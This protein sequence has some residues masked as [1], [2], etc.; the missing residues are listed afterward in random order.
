MATA[1]ASAIES[2][3]DSGF[4]GCYATLSRR[5]PAL[6]APARTTGNALGRMTTTD[7]ERTTPNGTAPGRA[8]PA[9]P[10]ARTAKPALAWRYPMRTPAAVRI[11]SPPA[12]GK[13]RA[14]SAASEMGSTPAAFRTVS[15]PTP[16]RA[17]SPDSG[18]DSRTSP[19]PDR[20]NNCTPIAV[21]PLGAS[22]DIAANDD[23]RHAWVIAQKAA[24]ARPPSGATQVAM[25][26]TGTPGIAANARSSGNCDATHACTAVDSAALS[27]RPQASTTGS[28]PVMPNKKKA[29]SDCSWVSGTTA[30]ATEVSRS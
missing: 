27:I 1:L 13:A 8:K 10:A 19:E 23:A 12:P 18:P 9:M 25:P 17:A 5:R 24:G 11:V 7:P 29:S 16:D 21:A 22:G 2:T 30:P 3:I 28:T 20:K 15:P 14:A 4:G 6:N 26:A